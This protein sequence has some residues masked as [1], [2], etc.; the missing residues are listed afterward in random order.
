MLFAR[1]NICLLYTFILDNFYIDARQVDRCLI[2]LAGLFDS[3]VGRKLEL[4]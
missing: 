4:R 1:K 3:A 2:F